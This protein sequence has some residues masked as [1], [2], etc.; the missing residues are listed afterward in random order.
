MRRRKSGLTADDAAL[1]AQVAE[2]V[3]P[4]RRRR[5][6]SAAAPS[7]TDASPATPAATPEP[8][9]PPARQKAPALPPLAPLDRLERRR[10][11][12]GTRPIEGRID[13]H[14]MRQARAYEAL[15]AFLADAQARGLGLVL[16]ITGKGSGRRSDFAL[17]DEPGVLRRIVPQWLRLPDLRSY[18]IGFE[19]AE[20][21]HGGAGAL[22]VRLRRPG[23]AGAPGRR[24]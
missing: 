14:G 3:E 17:T 15:C 24:R 10:L 19:E 7:D 20:R 12:R 16:V 21:G 18:V 1:W 13:L 6:R 5:A 23:R 11:A 9:P 22:Y 4:L 2:S 8:A